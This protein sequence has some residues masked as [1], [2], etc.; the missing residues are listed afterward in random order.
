MPSDDSKMIE[1]RRSNVAERVMS[2]KSLANHSKVP[3]SKTVIHILSTNIQR[4]RNIVK[5]CFFF[6]LYVRFLYAGFLFLYVR[7]ELLAGFLLGFFLFLLV[8]IV[9]FLFAMGSN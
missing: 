2:G 7:T 5:E 4:N 1:G 8:G 3:A 9:L 6:L